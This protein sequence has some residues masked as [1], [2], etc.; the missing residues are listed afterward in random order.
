MIQ[1][2]PNVHIMDEEIRKVAVRHEDLI[3][4]LAHTKADSTIEGKKI[5]ELV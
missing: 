3:H 1:R 5:L 4:Q 2:V